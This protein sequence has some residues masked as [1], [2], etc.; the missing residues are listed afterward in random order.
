MKV[1]ILTLDGY[2]NYGNLLQRYALSTIV[3]KLGFQ[4]F[5]IEHSP[6][7]F[8]PKWYWKFRWKEY[9]KFL[10][11]WRMFRSDFFNGNVGL[12]MVRQGR[13]KAWID[14]YINTENKPVDM[15]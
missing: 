3:K 12:E 6:N 9:V 14:R 2:F 15:K 13:I 11:N 10:L 8:L 1:C 5:S 4:V 7:H